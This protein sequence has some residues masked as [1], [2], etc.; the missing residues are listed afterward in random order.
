[1]YQVP[2]PE[3]TFY[4][5]NFFVSTCELKC[6]H[7]LVVLCFAFDFSLQPVFSQRSTENTQ[8]SKR[9]N[10]KYMSSVFSINN[11]ISP[12]FLIYSST[13]SIRTES[14]FYNIYKQAQ[15]ARP[16]SPTKLPPSRPPSSSSALSTSSQ[17]LL[18]HPIQLIGGNTITGFGKFS[19]YF[20]IQP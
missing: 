1:M 18:V 13:Y 10:C 3:L 4:F 2:T 9:P 19:S 5:L 7:V 11:K 15:H 8:L 14:S 17:F 20:S 6:I 12:F 16:P